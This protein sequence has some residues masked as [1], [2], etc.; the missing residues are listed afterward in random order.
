MKQ[1]L[2]IFIVAFT[3]LCNA[4]IVNIPD[5]N[6]KAKLLAANAN[7]SIASTQTPDITSSVQV[8]TFNKIDTNGDGEIQ[9]TEAAAI[10]YLNVTNSSI[11]NMEGIEYFTNLLVLNC[12]YNLL[13]SL[14]VLALARLRQLR[15]DVNKLPS[16]DVSRI[17]SL[18]ELD[19]KYNKLISLNDTIPQ[20]V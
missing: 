7:N 3:N 9:V 10:K 16:L 15:C 2:L 18:I 20:S 8:N 11:P 17:T 13:T 19:C 6:F 14:N 4:Q 1:I 12:S 5:A